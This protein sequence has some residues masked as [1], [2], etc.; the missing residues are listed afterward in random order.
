MA[1]KV[2][3]HLERWLVLW[4]PK[5]QYPLVPATRSLKKAVVDNWFGQHH[6]DEVQSVQ[7]R[8]RQFHL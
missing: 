2:T 5:I 3:V 7:I 8:I 6:G 1:A 4:C